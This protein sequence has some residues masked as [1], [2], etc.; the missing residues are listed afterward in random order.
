MIILQNEW[1]LAAIAPAGA[2]LQSL[3]NK[4]TGIEHMWSGDAAYWAKHSPVLF[5]IVGTLKQDTYYYHDQAYKLPRHGFAREKIFAAQ[6]ISHTEAVF[7]LVDDAA[8]RVAYPFEFLLQIRYR[9]S[10]NSLS[11]SYEIANPGKSELLFSIGAH[12]AF[13]LPFLSNS[14][15]ED[16]YLQFNQQEELVRWKLEDG[17]IGNTTEGLPS[18]GNRLALQH[19][20][21]YEDAIVLKNLKSNKI[22]LASDKHPHGIHFHFNDFQ[23]FGIWAAKDAPF[24]CLEPWCGVADSINHNQQL[25]D[26]EGIQ[27]LP[28]K[29]TWQRSWQVECL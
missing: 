22:T 23:F 4:T 14:S 24:I 12:P 25:E 2:E 20:L 10:E 7:S 21:F 18:T 1:L 29:A 13:A 8:T 26:K 19:N 16:Y 27:K 3:H 28:A 9:L 11:C 15:Y 17:L 6:Q 5:P